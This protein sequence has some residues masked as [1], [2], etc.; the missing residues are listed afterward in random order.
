MR[1][2]PIF[3]EFS[4]SA[5]IRRTGQPGHRC[6]QA[7][8]LSFVA[9]AAGIP[10]LGPPGVGR[11]HLAAA[12]AQRAIK[13]GCGACFVRACDLMED[14]RKAR[15]EHNLDRRRRVCLTPK[16]PAWTSSAAGPKTGT[17]PPPA[18]PPVRRY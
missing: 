18:A 7:T 9:E 2:K 4:V 8:G 15:A 12:L 14:L 1:V 11:T 13:R 10:L 6:Q 16:A 17:P 5:G 3:G